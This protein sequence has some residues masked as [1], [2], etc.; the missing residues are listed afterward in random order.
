[1]KKT[2]LIYFLSLVL[3]SVPLIAYSEPL[4]TPTETETIGAIP[5]VSAEAAILI[6]GTTGEILFEK[7]SK[8][9]MYP[10]SITKLMTILLA[11]ENGNLADTLTFSHDAI[12]SIEQGS[13]HIAIQEGEQITLEQG[14]Y[15]ILLRSAN[16]VS[17]GIAEYIDGDMTTFT[18]HMTARAKEL[19]CLN[20]NFINANGLYN[21]NHYTTAYDMSLIAKELLK[22][23]GYRKMMGSTYYEIPATNLQTEVRYLHGQHQMLNK[24]ST[25]YYEYATGG[26]TGFTSESQNTLVTFAKQGDTELIAVVLKCSSAEHYVDT[27]AL[28]DYGFENYKTTKLF[29]AS[30]YVQTLNVTETYKDK[31]D[32][33]GTITAAPETDIFQT[34]GIDEA[35]TDYKVNVDCPKTI[36]VP[37]QKGQ[38]IGTLTVTAPDR[39]NNTIPLLADKD[40]AV[41][42]PEARAALEK[43]Q[44]DALLGTIGKIILGVILLICLILCITR[45]IGN[46]KRKQRRKQKSTRKRPPS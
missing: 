28:F 14:L 30:D 43:E 44:K 29:S 46:Y 41:T 13:S 2:F 1:M 45:S 38:T 37:I 26:K 31:T 10:A 27:K 11:Y 3:T 18:A 19:G 7:N 21:E 34:L 39:S 8:E 23:E 17:N 35:A 9:K 16:E 40:V 6:D 32:T 24:N 4:P 20:T 22:Q 42:T 5:T 15:G 12:Y 36:E 33:I 25:Y